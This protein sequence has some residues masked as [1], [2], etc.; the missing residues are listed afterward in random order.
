MHYIFRYVISAADSWNYRLGKRGYYSNVAV[1]RSQENPLY[2]QG[3]SYVI[4][5]HVFYI[6]EHTSAD[7]A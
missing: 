4:L 6:Q 2:I 1:L 3:V 7:C 5:S